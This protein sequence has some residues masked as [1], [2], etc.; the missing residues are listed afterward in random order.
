[1][2]IYI[3]TD[4]GSTYTKMMAVDV[5][6]G[7]VVATSKA[8]TTIVEGIKKGYDKAL[9]ALLAQLGDVVVKG[10]YACSSAAGGLK[11]VSSGLVPDLTAKAARLAATSAGAKVMKTYA[12]ELTQAHAAEIAALE[13]DIVL[14]TGGIDGGNKDILIQ[15]AARLGSITKNFFVIVAGNRSAACEAM[16]ILE[17]CHKRA[18]ITENVMPSFGKLNIAPTK[19]AIRD[20]FIANIIKAKGLDEVAK[21]MDADIIPTPLSVYE[22]CRLLSQ[23]FEGEEGLGELMAYDIGGATTDVYSM[24]SGDPSF[25]NSFITGIKE[26]FAKRTVE[27]DLGMRYSLKALHDLAVEEGH[28]DPDDAQMQEW[29]EIC[30]ANPDVKPLGEYEKYAN[31][32]ALVAAYAIKTAANRHAGRLEKVFTANGEAFLQEG[33][34]LSDVK[35]IIGGGGAVINAKNPQGIMR[36]AI[37]APQDINIL[38][39]TSPQILLD[40][41]NTLSAMGLL[42]KENPSLALKILKKN[43]TQE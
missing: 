23:G 39:P 16:G 11:M 34:D 10:R 17:A 25:S 38:K 7:E 37:K 15:N 41:K 27:G 24:A 5:D 28:I 4:F 40:R 12:Y 32:D 33:K 36:E 30:Q 1:M 9:E 43:I 18:I 42:V 22:A 13:P 21:E 35:Y 20:L 26:P 2:E 6:K 29:L 31:I 14:L 3:L 19:K 8:F